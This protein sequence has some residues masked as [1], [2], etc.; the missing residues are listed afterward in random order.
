MVIVD[1]VEVHM[2]TSI[3]GGINEKLLESCN[4]STFCVRDFLK[5]IAYLSFGSNMLVW[6]SFHNILFEHDITILLDLITCILI[7]MSYSC[8]IWYVYVFAFSYIFPIWN[9]SFS[10]EE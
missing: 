7:N 6:I 4:C 9:G 5:N 8:W 1:H 10:I 3:K 2:I